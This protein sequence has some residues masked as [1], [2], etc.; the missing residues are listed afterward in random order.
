MG[1]SELPRTID[2]A[3]VGAGH[4]G[5]IA[6]RLLRAAGRE[7]ALLERRPRLG[8]GWQDR[9]DEFR[10]V[11][12]NWTLDLPG[13]E[14]T[15]D[16]DAF[17]NRDAIVERV[18]R[19]AEVVDAPVILETEVKRLSATNGASKA[20]PSD[21]RFRLDTTQGPLDARSVVVASGPFPVPHV[22]PISA[23][24]PSRITQVHSHHY[25]R[26]SDLPPGTVLIVGSGQT[27][28]Q[29]AEELTSAGRRVILAVGRCGR[30]PRRY[31]DRDIF[32]WLRRMRTIGDPVDA[33]L[34][35]AAQLPDPR[36]R[37]ACN[38]HLSGHGGGHT[39]DLRALGRDGVTLVGR[40]EGA[41]GERARFAPDL[42]AV[43]AFADS[44][45]PT[46]FRDTLERLIERTSIDVPPPESVEP[47]SWSPPAID[48]IDL[49]KEGVS[50]VLWSSGYRLG[51]D[52]WIDLPILDELGFPRTDRGMSE[53]AGLGFIGMPWQ[54]NMGSANLVGV[55]YD[56][57]D[58][59]ARLD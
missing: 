6:S 53:V 35:T 37:L 4:S 36:L 5:L 51:L 31:R 40:F 50:T 8:G 57:E 18:T 12:P 2:V 14:P 47:M 3:V 44:F 41:D 16:P 29:L 39:V 27:G 28:V 23:S 25:R 30:V 48:S 7:H 11:S 45:F 17:I 21:R 34:P 55:A 10:L 52:R 46:R 42:E 58:V 26:E 1:L 24:L 49:A 59:V 43:L 15:S 20:S 9:W 38:P 32:W 54:V 56:A 33:G 19:Y 13:L 22:P